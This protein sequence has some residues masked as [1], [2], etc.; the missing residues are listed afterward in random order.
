MIPAFAMITWAETIQALPVILS[1]IL[2][3]GLLSVDNALA[4]A[5]MANHLPGRQKFLALRL[6]IL[7]AYVFRGIALAFAAHIIANP[8]LK[9]IGAA[10][11]VYLM[12]QHLTRQGDGE[13][14]AT[15]TQERG[16]WGT[17]LAIEIM[18]L[19]LSVDNVVA[20]VALSPKLWVV[21]TGVFI[22]IL[23]LRFV[24][25]VCIRLLEKFPVLEHTA[26]LLIGYVGFI[27]LAELTIHDPP[28]PPQKLAAATV[29]AG[30][31]PATG[32]EVTGNV[33][34]P[35][36]SQAS[37]Q[38]RVDIFADAGSEGLSPTG[39]PASIGHTHAGQ[40]G[41]FSLAVPVPGTYWSQATRYIHISP[42]QKFLGISLI[43]GLSLLHARFAWMRA[44]TKV[45]FTVLRPPMKLVSVLVGTITHLL[46]WPFK[47][48]L[49]V[50]RDQPPVPGGTDD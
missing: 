30:T 33:P 12:C 5:A 3:E 40:D 41:H 22:G 18:D 9:L 7:G 17:I 11:L 45:L 36:D 13:D 19:S 49:G 34:A 42:F 6:G 26:F 50:K 46:V 37:G 35:K 48:L 27:L 38:V 39:Q 20:A 32:W 29:H 24:A 2:I 31:P 4:I 28:E 21:C 44:A 10:Y 43:I 14:G 25:G 15:E 1:L 47:L 8:W 23:A 16:F